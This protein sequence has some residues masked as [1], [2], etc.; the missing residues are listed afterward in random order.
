MRANP[1]L[2]NVSGVLVQLKGHR[3][4]RMLG[5]PTQQKVR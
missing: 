1:E 5:C 4:S 3:L 2:R